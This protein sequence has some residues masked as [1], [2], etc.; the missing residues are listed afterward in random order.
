V[1]SHHLQDSTHI[2]TNV[3]T[4]GVSYGPV[5]LEASGFHG[6][7]PDEKRWGIESG[8][9]DSF[10]SR[11]TITPGSHWA[12]QFSMGRIAGREAT[13]PLR[14]SLRSTAS[15]THFHPFATGHWATTLIWGRNNDLSYTQTP[16]LPILPRNG[17]R[18]LHV[19]SVPTRIPQQ[20]YNSYLAESTLKWKRNWIWGRAES[21]DRDS[22]FLFKEAPFVL[23]VDEQRLARVQ[24]YTAGYERELP[25]QIPYLSTGL[26]GQ[27]TFYRVPELLSPIYGS[28]PAGVQLFFRV[29]LAGHR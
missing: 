17:I 3:A 21:A 23:L 5:T 12:G 10:A 20:I 7:E 22:T 28:S 15:V 25:W 24:A 11:I 4:L 1:I 19:V 8:A 13:H 6:R 18:P 16:N 2:A 27:V 29:R 14:P 9:I 26:G